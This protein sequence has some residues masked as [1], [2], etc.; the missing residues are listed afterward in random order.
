MSVCAFVH[1]DI[2]LLVFVLTSAFELVMITTKNVE[3]V[4]GGML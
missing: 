2:F 4:V 1:T 3:K